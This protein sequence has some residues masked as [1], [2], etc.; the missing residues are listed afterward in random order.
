ME[1]NIGLFITGLFILL[2]SLYRIRKVGTHRRLQ[3]Q[4]EQK[5]DVSNLDASGNTRYVSCFSHNWVMENIT[6]STHSRFGAMLQDHLANNT[7]FAGIWIGLIVGTSS[8]I[9]TM[10]L[11]ES[12]RTVG[13]VIVIFMFGVAISV[14]PGGPRYSE[15]LLDAVLEKEIVDLNAQDFVYVKIANDT[16]KRA[17]VVNVV[18]ATL[19]IVL[20]PW[21]HLLPTALAGVIAVFT[22]NIL[23]EPATF[24][25]DH[26]IGAAIL[27]IAFVIGF[28]SFICFKVGQRVISPEEETEPQV[29]W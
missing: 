9:L 17:V 10:L 5:Y 11:V 20:S 13:T 14:G 21:G 3:H 4:L 16:I 24:L 1:Y 27:Y 19:F 18:L 28:L 29:Q 7:L 23:W 12:L 26:N 2:V 6:K 22:V 25:I 15:N 8:M